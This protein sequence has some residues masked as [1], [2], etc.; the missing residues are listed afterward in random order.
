MGKTKPTVLH[1]WIDRNL[2]SALAERAVKENRSL[3]NL[4]ETAL[5][6]FL[7]MDVGFK[8]NPRKSRN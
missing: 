6:A 8:G 5:Y 3:A 1:M 7:N 4:I 2:K